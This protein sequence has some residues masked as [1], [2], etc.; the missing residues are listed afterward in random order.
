MVSQQEPAEIAGD[1]EA[2]A[3]AQGGSEEEW[4]LLF[5]RH[6]PVL[7]RIAALMT[8]SRDAA[9]DCVQEAFVRILRADIRHRDGSLRAYLST[10]VYRLALKENIRRNKHASLPGDSPESL[11]LSPLDSTL[12]DERQRGVR[13]VLESLPGVQ[14]DVLVLRL[15]GG[16]SY[17]DIAGITGVS[18]GTV[19][20][21]M[22]YAVKAAQKELRK[23]GLI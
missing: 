16:H 8:G 4:S 20:S 19:K 18:I 11:D 3:R 1:W 21:R 9:H 14:R 10:I 23:R 12:A 22:F 5:K 15:H 17:E 13:R 7:L 6:S 2:L